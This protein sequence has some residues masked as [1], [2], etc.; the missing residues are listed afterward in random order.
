MTEAEW[1]AAE[2]PMPMLEF[3]RHGGRASDRK[4]RLFI[5]H[6]TRTLGSVFGTWQDEC[7]Q[8][9]ERVA[10]GQAT[11]EDLERFLL[12]DMPELWEHRAPGGNLLPVW[13]SARLA[14]RDRF[15]LV[16]LRP[17]EIP[18]PEHRAAENLAMC[19]ELRCIFGNPFR[20]VSV[21][22]A[23]LAWN[24]GTVR[25]LAEAIYAER[26]FQRLPILAD[27]LEEAGCDNADILAHLRVPGPHARGCWVLD[28][29]L[30]KDR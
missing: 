12:R 8:M 17:N 23:W 14:V 28:L 15:K 2:D 29:L 21:P 19:D 18:K 9:H 1:L 3:L 16:P 25:R 27:A 10:E 30:S 11:E 24:E 5:A 13:Q 6:S 26:A 22:A 4:L 20:P 7:S